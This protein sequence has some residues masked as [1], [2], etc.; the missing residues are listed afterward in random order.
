MKVS[1]LSQRSGVSVASIKYYLREG[2]LTGGVPTATNQA[3]YSEQHVRRL[4][5]IRSLID[6]GGLSISHVRA[7]LA[8][9]DDES[10][11]MHDAFGA[12][13]H[14]LDE[15]PTETRTTDIQTVYDEVQEWLSSRGWDIDPDAPAP[16]R[17]AELVATLRRFDFPT[18][19]TDFDSVADMIERTAQIEVEYARA[20]PDRTSAVETMLIGTVI[21]ER[22]IVEVRR[23][24]LEAA[25]ARI[26]IATRTTTRR[27]Q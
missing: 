6:I 19:L 17:L 11:P 4:R 15:A 9:V 3:V 26:D 22:A 20:M 25:S 14:G 2:L 5:L 13:M 12:V 16:H 10:T 18:T 24:A 1:E 7:T 21:L 27:P 23:L 8:E